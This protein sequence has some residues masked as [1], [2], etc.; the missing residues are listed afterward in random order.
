MPM[1]PIQ[2]IRQR[3]RLVARLRAS[4]S[5]TTVA[6]VVVKPETASKTAAMGSVMAPSSSSGSA[7]TPPSSSQ[8]NATVPRASLRCSATCSPREAALMEREKAAT[9]IMATA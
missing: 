9:R 8:V 4:T 6:P 5:P 3:H 2:C 1:P 7:P